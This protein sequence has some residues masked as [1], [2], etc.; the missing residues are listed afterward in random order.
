MNKYYKKKKFCQLFGS[1]K[2]LNVKSK[3]FFHSL[4]NLIKKNQI[5]IIKN[6]VLNKKN[7]QLINEKQNLIDEKI[8]LEKKIKK[9]EV[10]GKN[11]EISNIRLLKSLNTK[12]KYEELV[13]KCKEMNP[14]KLL[15]A[16]NLI[17]TF[18]SLKKK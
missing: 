8:K 4:S 17:K 12:V 5:L 2:K 7:S 13:N 14:S 11:L 18:P 9:L 1:Q 15:T 16:E 6:E 10:E 3:L